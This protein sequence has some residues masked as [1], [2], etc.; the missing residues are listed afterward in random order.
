MLSFFLTNKDEYIGSAEYCDERVC[1]SVCVC[2]CVRMR[3]CVCVCLCVCATQFHYSNF[4][5]R[6][7][8]VLYVRLSVTS[9]YCIE[10]TKRTVE[11]VEICNISHLFLYRE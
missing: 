9:R 8:L 5:S 6:D 4:H 3:V 1:L 10:R 11:Q 7:S 2:V